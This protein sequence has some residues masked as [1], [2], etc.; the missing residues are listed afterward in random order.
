MKVERSLSEVVSPTLKAL[1]N[2][3]LLLVSVDENGRPNA[4]TIGWGFAGILWGRPYF[5]VA[6]RPSRFTFSLIEKTS[7]FT[8]NV[9]R[10]GMEQAVSFCGTVSGRD[11]DKF[12]E[13]GFTSRP[14]KFVRSPVIEECVIHYECKVAYKHR[15][16]EAGISSGIISQWY[17]GGDLHT[18]YFGEI[19]AIYADED[20]ERSLP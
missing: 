10:K 9:P 5:I 13:C 20:Y 3:G 11:Y 19:L 6:V 18:L 7:D 12:K 1:K 8:V 17:P 2:P 4:M 14:S 16:S 15:L